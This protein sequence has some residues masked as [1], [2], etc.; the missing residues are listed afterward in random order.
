MGVDLKRIRHVVLDLDGTIYLSGRLFSWTLPFFDALHDLEIGYTFLTN[1]SSLGRRDYVESLRSKGLNA[2][3]RNVHT[4]GQATIDF[5]QRHRPE[6]RRLFLLGTD[7]LA[8]EFIE[9]GFDLCGSEADGESHAGG[10]PD[11]VVVAFDPAL[12]FARLCKAAYWL[13]RGKPFL[14]THPDFVCPTDR[15]TV[16]IDCGSVCAC[17]AAATGR[18]PEAVIGK[19]DKR[20]LEGLLCRENLEPREVA[21]VGDRLYTDIALARE[22]GAVAVLVASGETTAEAARQSEF[23]PDYILRDVGELGELLR[24][25][26]C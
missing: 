5:L 8:A 6:L 18:T 11:A 3:V 24:R 13:E 23:R 2:D 4:S 7:R 20:M 26:Q 12:D 14:A 22:T 17:L 19:P 15:P 25:A 16:L 1:N 21:V 10:E 9:A